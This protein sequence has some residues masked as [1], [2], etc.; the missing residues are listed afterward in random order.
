MIYRQSLRAAYSHTIHTPWPTHG[1]EKPAQESVLSFSDHTNAFH[2]INKRVMFNKV[3]AR[4]SMVFYIRNEPWRRTPFCVCVLYIDSLV[5]ITDSINL[6]FCLFLNLS[7]WDGLCDL[8]SVLFNS[9]DRKWYVPCGLHT[10][11]L[12]AQGLDSYTFDLCCLNSLCAQCWNF[13]NL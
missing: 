9:A 5:L 11:A 1:Q 3:N 6:F 8:W 13:L 10:W 4:H 7:K 2:A 12:V